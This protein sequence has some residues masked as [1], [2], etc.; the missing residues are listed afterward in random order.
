MATSR[1][2]RGFA[3]AA[4]VGLVLSVAAP[5]Q[6]APAPASVD[7][8]DG[9]LRAASTNPCS[10]FPADNIWNTDIRNAP[11]HAKSSTWLTSMKAPS[12]KLHP[13]F[14]GPT[15]GLPFTL[16]DSSHATVSIHFDYAD[17]S[18][19]GPYPFGPDT[20]IEGGSDR[21]AIM[22]DTDTCTLYELFNAR[23]NNGHP[24]AGSGA[25]WDLESNALRPNGWTSADAA[26]LPIY[27]GLLSYD[28]VLTGSVDH[29][30]RFT[31]MPTD[32]SHL[33]PAR[34]DA[35]DKKG[36][37]YPPMGA[38]FRM[39][40]GFS[41]DGYGDE[42]KVIL[43]AMKHYGLI[44]A[45]NGSNWYFQG[46]QDAQWPDSL[47]QEPKRIPASA[48]VAIDESGLKIDANSGQARQ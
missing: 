21:H 45:D 32:G 20:P 33:W 6:A 7:A 8:S 41:T 16:T 46:V 30:I 17:E 11:V 13:D 2:L 18:D 1:R 14:G 12:T 42:A 15:Y 38:R 25:I 5:T 26:G 43:K 31:A 48:F 28:E 44:L 10:I 29:A 22:I 23:W 4:L 39:K 24:T 36:K 47:V 19:P 37:T 40:K 35:S 34:H 27:P 9:L 3:S